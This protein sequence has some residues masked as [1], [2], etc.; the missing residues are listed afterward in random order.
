MQRNEETVLG[1]IALTLINTLIYYS[2][3][4]LG[5]IAMFGTAATWVLAG[6]GGYIAGRVRSLSLMAVEL[7]AVLIITALQLP[8]T[9]GL[10]YATQTLTITITAYL[11]GFAGGLSAWRGQRP[12]PTLQPTRVSA[13]ILSIFTGSIGVSLVLKALVSYATGLSPI[14]V[15]GLKS[16]LLQMSTLTLAAAFFACNARR[17]GLSHAL[18]LF[19][20][21]IIAYM[22]PLTLPLTLMPSAIGRGTHEVWGI[23]DE[24]EVFVGSPVRR[25]AGREACRP[26]LSLTLGENNHVIITGS[27]GTGKTSIAKLITRGALK[28][29]IPVLVLDVHG[30]YLGLQG[31][32]IISPISNPVNLL[33]TYGKKPQVRAEEVADSIASAFRLGNV[34]KAALYHA[35]THTYRIFDK[36]TLA[37]LLEILSDPNA[38]TYLGFTH[39]VIRSLIPYIKS[40]TG[41]EEG[42][43]RWVDPTQILEGA[44]VVNLSEVESRSIQRVYVDGLIDCLFALEKSLRRPLLIVAEEAHRFA[45][46]ERSGL[47]R[48]FREG[49]KF[50]LN[51]VAVTQEP[52]SIDIS[53][54]NNCAYILSTQLTDER[55]LNYVAKI[56]S[57]G[58]QRLFKKVRGSLARLGKFEALLWE[59]RG[60][61]ILISVKDALHKNLY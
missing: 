22:A 54:F 39:N 32:R 51:V 40:L 45:V 15:T 44:T 26:S 31:S 47:T 10:G 23:T 58:D 57:G 50:G 28:L 59:R 8:A 12:K 18:L 35:I 38:H 43:V 11:I 6:I 19:I 53:L 3:S 4:W 48:A 25:L 2:S 13:D 55:S 20:G 33:S 60:C 30:E 14:P 27:S 5:F 46:S 21:G 56:M 42:N 41:L 1:A 34:Q 49:R 29:G 36:P 37:D 7:V 17:E 24:R 61:V 16:A 9:A 52:Y